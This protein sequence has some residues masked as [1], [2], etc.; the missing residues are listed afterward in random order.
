[1]ASLSQ[2]GPSQGGAHLQEAEIVSQSSPDHESQAAARLLAEGFFQQS[3]GSEV[4]AAPATC[5]RQGRTALIRGGCQ[6]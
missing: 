1:M 2:E 5:P 4:P 3:A 6:S